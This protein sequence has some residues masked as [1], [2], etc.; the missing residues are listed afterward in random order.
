MTKRRKLGDVS[1]IHNELIEKL[2]CASKTLADGS[3]Q[4]KV[5]A[6]VPASTLFRDLCASLLP[7]SKSG[8]DRI[9]EYLL[10]NLN[11]IVEGDELMVISGINDWPRRVR[12]LRTESGWPVYSGITL[13]QVLEEEIGLEL[14]EVEIRA[15][16]PSQYVLLGDKPDVDAAER[17]KYAN[18]LRKSDLSV[19]DRILDFLRYSVG[20]PVTGEELR[21]VAADKTE[22]AR[23]V[24]ELRTEFGWPVV[25][26]QTGRPD[27]PVGSY[28]LEMDRQSPVHDRKIPDQLRAQVL[29]RD[30]FSCQ[31]CQ[32]HISE[33]NKADPRILELH[34]IIHHADGGGNIEENLVTLCNICHDAR[35]RAERK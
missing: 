7:D 19:R 16:K 13:R 28:L 8:R 22:W 10:I 2:D 29:R 14:E 18:S 21:Y 33:W 20:K 31:T 5:R 27:L 25:T 34:H 35:H 4:E 17:W 12:E 26:K 3:L 23:R 11:R 32:W 15:L 30:D 6:L 1:V 9:L 24:R